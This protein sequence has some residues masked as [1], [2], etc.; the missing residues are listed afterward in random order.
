MSF[1]EIYHQYS[2]EEIKKEIYAIPSRRVEEALAKE[3][4]TPED[5]MALVSPAAE[6]YLPAMMEMSNTLTQKR[7]G[8]T[9]QLYIPIYLSNECHNICTY[10]GFSF[11]NKIPRKILT[12]D[13]IKKEIDYIKQWPFEH[14]L[15][16][17]G[18]DNKRAGLPYF[19]DVLPLFLNAFAQVSMEVQPLSEQEYA[20]LRKAGVYSILLYQ[21]TYHAASYKTFHPK[22]KKSNFYYRLETPDRIGVNGFYKI[23]LGIL[24]GLDDW[25]TDSFFVALHYQYL[26]KK[27]WKTRYSI[28]F[29]RI[30]PHEGENFIP[31]AVTDKN[32]IQ[33]ICAYRLLD[34]DLELSLSTR[35]PRHLR[36]HAFL[37]GITTMSAFSKTNP[38]GYATE[39]ESLEQFSIEDNRTPDAI[40]NIIMEKQYEPV[41]KD[42]EAIYSLP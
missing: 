24:L 8:K 41:W 9:V 15:L 27:Y 10:C 22:G 23:G 30:R 37:F 11:T 42:W 32:L 40:A 26:R 31:Y 6:K 18:E 12:K 33:L 38:G 13:E 14:V 7:F 29:P 19:L 28:S 21:E 17:T 5:F 4:R 25:R 2:F 34:E 3:K 36:D 20:Q 1:S 39:K 16:V 35:E